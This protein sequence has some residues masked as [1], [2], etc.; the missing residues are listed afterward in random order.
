MSSLTVIL[1]VHDAFEVLGPCLASLERVSPEADIIVVDDASTDPRV[2]SLLEAWCGSSPCH[3][4][5]A[6][7]AEFG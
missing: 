6:A 1:P 7:E 3:S 4:V 5:G 2:R